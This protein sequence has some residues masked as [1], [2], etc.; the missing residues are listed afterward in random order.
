M[1][2]K[3]IA[4]G[5]A[6][7]ALAGSIALT[8]VASA[9]PSSCAPNQVRVA[10]G[11]GT[12]TEDNDN[13]GTTESS[14]AA[15]TGGLIFRDENGRDL[16]SGIGEGDRF[17]WNG[18]K[19]TVNGEVLIWIKQTTSGNGGWGSLYSGWVKAQYTQAPVLFR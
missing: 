17:V 13:V 12:V 1:N 6:A 16:G 8:G 19:R 18:E 11:C 9:A 7:A 3:T 2:K 15:G 5:A 14:P 4:A 10:S